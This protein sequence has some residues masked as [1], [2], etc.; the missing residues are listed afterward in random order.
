MNL[1]RFHKV[2]K[3]SVLVAT[4]LTIPVLTLSGL[5][6]DIETASAKT[7]EEI[8]REIE[9]KQKALEDKQKAYDAAK[10]EGQSLSARSGTLEDQLSQVNEELSNSE[11]E[12]ADTEKQIE[13]LLADIAELEVYINDQKS[14]LGDSAVNLYQMSQMSDVERLFSSEGFGEY[15]VSSNLRERVVEQSRTKIDELASQI[16]LVSNA[17]SLADTQRLSLE[18]TIAELKTRQESLNKE[19]AQVKAQIADVNKQKTGLRT[20]MSQL[21]TAIDLLEA[22]Q[23]R[24]LEEEARRMGEGGGQVQPL[25]PGQYYFR[26]RGR[27]LYDG[28]AVGMSQYGAYGMAGKGWTYDQILKFYYTGVSVADYSLNSQISI[29]YCPNTSKYPKASVTIT[30]SGST[31]KYPDG[32]TKSTQYKRIGFND[33]L[34]GLGEMPESWPV[35]AR[36]AQMVAARTYAAKYTSNGSDSKPICTTAACQVV[37]LRT[38]GTDDDFCDNGDYDIAVATANKTIKYNGSL[39]TAVYHASARGHTENNDVVFSDKYGKGTPYAY[40]RG[41]DD[42]AYTYKN[43]YYDL[44]TRTD[45]YSLEE[46][47]AICASNSYTNVGQLQSIQITRGASARAWKVTLNGTAGSKTVAG[48]YFKAEV[49]NDWVYDHKPAS[50]RDYI[51]ST[52]FYLLQYEG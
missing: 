12:L 44:I 11:V 51:Y 52:E 28:H 37:Y 36:K 30:P 50:E 6:P 48:W 34:G 42:S 46:L 1:N 49:F 38:G 18:T 32:S 45:G 23:K 19:L 2:G 26:S 39:I 24:I 25:E 35:E 43:K 20:S 31:C 47:S 7:V 16:E 10:L 22:E 29:K 27:D 21:N 5:I 3:L 9:E 14:T 8:I 41:V 4:L 33:Y 17:K 13:E 40:L 15:V